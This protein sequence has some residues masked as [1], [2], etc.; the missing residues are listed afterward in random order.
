MDNNSTTGVDL[1]RSTGKVIAVSRAS[2]EKLVGVVSG[3]EFS[4]EA[5][6]EINGEPPRKKIR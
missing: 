3:E 4:Q 2:Y 6:D 1:W 5:D